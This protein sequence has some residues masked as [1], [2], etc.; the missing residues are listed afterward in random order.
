MRSTVFVRCSVVVLGL[1]ALGVATVQALNLSVVIPV[2]H[3][4]IAWSL[5]NALIQL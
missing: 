1:A 5:T 2:Q 3:L 4:R